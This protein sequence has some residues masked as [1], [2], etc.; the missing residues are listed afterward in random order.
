MEKRSMDQIKAQRKE[1]KR[2]ELKA[3]IAKKAEKRQS[4]AVR[5]RMKAERK[6]RKGEKLKS[7][8]ALKVEKCQSKLVEAQM[9]AKRKEN[10][11]EKLKAKIDMKAQKIQSEVV[12]AELKYNA[13]RGFLQ[14]K[15]VNIMVQE[16]KKILRTSEEMTRSSSQIRSNKSV[17][18]EM[19]QKLK[20]AKTRIDQ[21]YEDQITALKDAHE[22]QMSELKIAHETQVFELLKE[23][24]S[25]EAK[26]AA[27]KNASEL[28]FNLAR[29]NESQIRELSQKNAE[30]EALNLKLSKERD[31]MIMFIKYGKKMDNLVSKFENDF[32]ENESTL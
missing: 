19:C 12:G 25:Y 11:T 10:K 21:L 9:K 18:V 29:A 30:L 17:I 23:K 13:Q 16:D 5:A 15:D 31:S 2:K 27:L 6:E 24:Y 4:K 7:K 20:C 26:I 1:R 8:I 32:H 3:K 22:D 14:H 28:N